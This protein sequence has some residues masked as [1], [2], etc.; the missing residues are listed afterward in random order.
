MC[1]C[2]Y[3]CR[4]MYEWDNKKK[5]VQQIKIYFKLSLFIIIIIA[6]ETPQ[7]LKKRDLVHV[8]TR[9]AITTP[10]IAEVKAH[11]TGGERGGKS[12]Q[13]PNWGRFIVSL[14][15]VSLCKSV[16]FR[17][18]IF[19]FVRKTSWSRPGNFHSIA[20]LEREKERERWHLSCANQD[21]RI[22][23]PS[24]GSFSARRNVRASRWISSRSLSRF[25][26]KSCAESALCGRNSRASTA[27]L[28]SRKLRNFV[29][30]NLSRQAWFKREAILLGIIFIARQDT[31][32]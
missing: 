12:M 31:R 25:R 18:V 6:R 5:V 20:W 21:S 2:V 4:T 9:R 15:H 16:G 7:R 8:I 11:D 32:K 3:L 13:T 28:R 30:V 10:H 14:M 24:C 23:G 1:V 22:L 17:D 19:K 27:T 26:Q 29:P